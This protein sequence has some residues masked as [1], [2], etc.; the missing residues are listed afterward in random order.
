MRNGI[1]ISDAAPIFSLVLLDQLHLLTHFFDDV[2]I[3]NAV[4]EEVSRDQSKD[5]H[6]AVVDFFESRVRSIN[7][8]NQLQFVM[9]YGESEAVLLYQEMNADFLLIDDKKARTYAENMGYSLCW[10]T[11]F[12]DTSKR[13]RNYYNF[14]SSICSAIE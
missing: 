7:E 9:D 11:R 8:V 2:F 4:W 12:V 5:D 13:K 10:Y 3:P 6:V 1:V 14:A